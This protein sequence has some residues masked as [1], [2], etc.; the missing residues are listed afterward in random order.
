M[1]QYAPGVGAGVFLER[2]VRRK[3]TGGLLAVYILS[4]LLSPVPFPLRLCAARPQ[5]GCCLS[6]D[7]HHLCSTG[8][9]S[10]R[11]QGAAATGNCSMLLSLL[12]PNPASHSWCHKIFHSLCWLPQS[13]RSCS[14]RTRPW[15]A[16]RAIPSPRHGT[17]RQRRCSSEMRGWLAASRMRLACTSAAPAAA[18]MAGM[19][20]LAIGSRRLGSFVSWLLRLA[21]YAVHSSFFCTFCALA[22]YLQF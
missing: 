15:G 14:C 10:C 12:R 21:S 3:A 9:G 2:A 8:A 22:S 6:C 7:L 11:V 20:R 5:V 4:S 13:S 16:A 18:L 17:A 19:L 1:R